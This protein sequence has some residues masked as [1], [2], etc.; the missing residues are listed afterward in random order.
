MHFYKGKSRDH[1]CGKF[2]GEYFFIYD[3]F[4]EN[5][6]FFK[7][8]MQKLIFSKFELPK[9]LLKRM[10]KHKSGFLGVIKGSQSTNLENFFLFNVHSRA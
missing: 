2:Y 5:A 1:F 6:G 7:K 8:K 10:G 9:K 3:I 4:P